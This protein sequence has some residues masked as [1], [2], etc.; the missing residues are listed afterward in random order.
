MD[1]DF[2]LNTCKEN[3]IDFVIVGPEAPLTN[4]ITDILQNENIY[5][6]GPDSKAAELEGSK[7]FM[8]DLCKKYEIPSADSE[9]FSDANSAISYISLIPPSFITAPVGL[10]GE[11]I[12]IILVFFVT[13]YDIKFQSQKHVSHSQKE[14]GQSE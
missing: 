4:G 14:S 8:K 12:I 3:S 13:A 9:T 10:L 6:F 5:V 2:V 7:I 1:N 11:L